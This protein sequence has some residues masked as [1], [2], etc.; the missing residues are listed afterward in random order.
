[1]W[2]LTTSLALLLLLL[3]LPGFQ[4]AR[5]LFLYMPTYSHIRGSL[6]VATELASHGH[7]VWNALSTELANHKGMQ[8][9]GVNILKYESVDEYDF[10]QM[11]LN[12]M[13]NAYFQENGPPVPFDLITEICDRILRDEELFKRIKDLNFDLIIFDIVPL[14][15]ML[16]T[17]A[18]RLDIPFIFIGAAFEPQVSRTPFVPSA[19]PFIIS[20]RTPKMDFGTR[21]AN[22]ITTVLYVFFY[23]P[24]CTYRPV[25]T[26]APEKPYISMESLTAKAWLWLIDIEPLLDYPA[27]TLP[28]V[29]LIGSL[30][31]TEPKPL[32]VEYKKFMDESKEGVVIVSFGSNVKS[33]PD[34]ISKRLLEALSRTN[35]RYIFKT[36]KKVKVG[37]YVLLTDWMPQ[38][39]LLAHPN[40]KLFITHCGASG[41]NEAFLKGVP[42]IGFPLFGDQPYNSMK[43]VYHGF[44]L[45]MDLKTFTVADLVSNI[46]EVIQNSSYSQN[47][48]KAAE[49][50]KLRKRSPKDE[51]VYW[52]E[53]V[54]KYGA[55]HLRSYCQDMPLYQYLCLDVIGLVLFILHMCIFLIWKLCSYCCRKTCNQSKQ[56]VE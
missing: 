28:N 33:L 35:Y 45:K 34:E 53:H 25:A 9:P 48:K 39:D 40:T 13:I 47:I 27:A 46:N 12:S 18:Y 19:F 10:D 20:P 14:A 26:Y 36:D 30:S 24:F 16:T 51:A 41:L 31:A 29:K 52:I 44:G 1:M 5:I 7:V 21:V 42:M 4:A 3:S 6:N 54:L 22:A 32:P 38:S 15:R 2:A 37:P 50:T 17:I 56:K 49:I 8:A 55:A 11:I 23:D 43:V